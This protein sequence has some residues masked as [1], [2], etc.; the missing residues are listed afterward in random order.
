M[1][2]EAGLRARLPI[3]GLGLPV[4]CLPSAG[5]TND[6]ALGLAESGAPEGTLVVAEA[7]TRGRG[8]GGSTWQTRPGTALALSLVL[9]PRAIKPAMAW[10]IGVAGALAVAE[11]LETEGAEPSIKWPNDILLGGRKVAGLLVDGSWEGETLLYAVL[12]MGVN[13]LVGSAPPDAS[14]DFPATSVEEQLGRPVDRAGLLLATLESLARWKARLGTM[15]LI[16]AWWKRMAF[17]DQRVSVLERGHE[18]RGRLS[19]V[20]ATGGV[21]LVLDSHERV[22]V[23]ASATRLRPIDSRTE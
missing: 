23:P 22:T 3:G 18:V 5:S 8:R 6:V 2:T 20:D 14:V 12:G 9:R 7:Q 10:G 16:E 21:I 11:A 4:Y 1:L 15:D 13:V 17:R 19:G